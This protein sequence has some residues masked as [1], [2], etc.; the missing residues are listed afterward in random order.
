M[1]D[2]YFILRAT[3][4]TASDLLDVLFPLSGDPIQLKCSL[5]SLVLK[6]HFGLPKR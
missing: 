3:E 1:M 2:F 4:E 5:F 6:C